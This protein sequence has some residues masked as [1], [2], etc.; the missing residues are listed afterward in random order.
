MFNACCIKD[1]KKLYLKIINDKIFTFNNFF[2]LK[3]INSKVL[4]IFSRVQTFKKLLK[5]SFFYIL[6]WFLLCYFYNILCVILFLSF[7]AF[8]KNNITYIVKQHLRCVADGTDSGCIIR[9][10]T[11]PEYKSHGV[12]VLP[13]TN[14]CYPRQKI[15][16]NKRVSLGVAAQKAAFPW[17]KRDDGRT[18]IT[19]GKLMRW[20]ASPMSLSSPP[21]P[22]RQTLDAYS[23]RYTGRSLSWQQI[24]EFRQTSSVYAA[25]RRR[26]PRTTMR[27][28][29]RRRRRRTKA[30]RATVGK[31]A[32][33][34]LRIFDPPDNRS[35][36]PVRPR[37]GR[38]GTSFPI[39]DGVSQAAT[40]VALLALNIPY[41]SWQFLRANL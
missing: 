8:F 22:A 19:G 24:P 5:K 33:T 1:D 39:L 4:L 20:V 40:R 23:C 13:T 28:R 6:H 31:G 15:K 16:K 7:I 34:W 41:F 37:R 10:I 32:S 3:F 21:S 12:F 29:R 14:P 25:R 11:N 30:A 36:I 2:S 35:R 9:S 27:K 18:A 38:R 26:E 17:A